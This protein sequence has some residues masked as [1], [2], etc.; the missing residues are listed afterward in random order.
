MID[1]KEKS[2]EFIKQN[3]NLLFAKFANPKIFKPSQTPLSLFMVERDQSIKI[4]SSKSIIS[5]KIP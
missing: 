3:K 1:V 4:E 5:T 2:K